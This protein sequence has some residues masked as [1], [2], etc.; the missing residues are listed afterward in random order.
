MWQLPRATVA[1]NQTAE[2]A[3]RLLLQDE[4]G[5]EG[6]IKERLKTLR[7]TVTHHKIQLDCFAARFEEHHTLKS[8]FSWHTPEEIEKLALP[9]VMRKLL[10]GLLAEPCGG[11]L[12][13][14]R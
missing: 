13:L 11:L 12:E 10:D 2:D 6:E 9:S 14:M 8:T 3:A 1:E 5:I 7:H 4:L